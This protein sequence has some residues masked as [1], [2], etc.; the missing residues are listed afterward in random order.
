[1]HKIRLT[2][3]FT[4]QIEHI[5]ESHELKTYAHFW[6][7]PPKNHQFLTIL[8]LYQH[9]KNQFIPSIHS[10]DRANFR[11]LL[12]EW[13][14]PFLII[15]TQKNFNKLLIFTNFYQYAKNQAISLICSGDVADIKMVQ[16]ENL[17]TILITKME[18]QKKIQ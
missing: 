5:L 3:T 6:L 14:C 2:P 8:N 12:Q 16:Y 18:H 9:A 10:W 11:V 17:T 13:P 1:M 7:H 15:P 4:L